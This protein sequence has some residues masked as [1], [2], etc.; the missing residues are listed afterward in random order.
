MCIHTYVYIYIEILLIIPLL[1]FND[2]AIVEYLSHLR[3]AG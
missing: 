1:I 2:Y 3:V